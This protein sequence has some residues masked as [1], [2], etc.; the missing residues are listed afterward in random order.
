MN[1][2]KKNT[3]NCENNDKEKNKIRQPKKKIK[4]ECNKM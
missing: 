4:Q 3:H 2:Q 1:L